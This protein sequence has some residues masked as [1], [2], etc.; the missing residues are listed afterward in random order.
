[1]KLAFVFIFA[2]FINSSVVLAQGNSP[3][4]TNVSSNPVQSA[5][6]IENIS[7]EMT[8]I[9]KSLQTFNKRMKEMLEQF[10]MN[11]GNQLNEK[12]QKLLLG[13]EILNRAEQ[14]VEI[15][16]KFQIELADKEAAIKTRIA[17]VEY[18]SKTEN[19]ERTVAVIGTL[20]GDETREARR[21]TLETE[22]QSLQNLLAQ[23]RRNLSQTN[24]E[25]E[26]AQAMVTRL[27]QKIIPQIELELTG[28]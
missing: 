4:D 6:P 25:L 24:Y 13:F 14:R 9:S 10:A 26:Q 8:K 27:R 5:N 21:R 2:L 23:I 17:I 20:R 3:A 18:D 28:M 19:V 16:Q 7:A 22:R 15:L 11:K 12:Q 1:M